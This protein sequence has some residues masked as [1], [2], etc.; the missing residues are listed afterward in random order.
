MLP[1]GSHAVS[2][3]QLVP[4]A[5]QRLFKPWKQT[6]IIR[7]TIRHKDGDEHDLKISFLHYQRPIIF[8]SRECLFESRSLWACMQEDQHQLG[9][10]SLVPAYWTDRHKN[11]SSSTESRGWRLW[12]TSNNT[13]WID[14]PCKNLSLMTVFGTPW[15]LVLTVKS[16][17]TAHFS[18]AWYMYRWDECCSAINTG[19]DLM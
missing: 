2:A 13:F 11:A 6:S 18:F 1:T 3:C 9:V 19:H 4:K 8:K 12:S 5:G 10:I 16:K 14:Q 15:F 17:G 7:S